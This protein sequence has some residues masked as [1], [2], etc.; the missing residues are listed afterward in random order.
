MA[1]VEERWEDSIEGKYY[2][3]SECILCSLCANIAP[4]SFR[5]SDDGDHDIVYNQ[6][7]TNEQIELA[8]DAMEQCPV[9]A[10]GNDG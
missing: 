7:V 2:V 1:S 10:I 5:E 8:E 6:P 9:E 3:D 4:D